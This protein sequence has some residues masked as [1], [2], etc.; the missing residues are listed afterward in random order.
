M[1][2]NLA[3]NSAWVSVS[4]FGPLL[5]DGVLL[6]VEDR[7]ELGDLLDGDLDLVLGGLEDL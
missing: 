4:P 1:K 7:L 3:W 5:G 6:G 2:R